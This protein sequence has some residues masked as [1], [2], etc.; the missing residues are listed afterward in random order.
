ME[1]VAELNHSLLSKLPLGVQSV[2]KSLPLSDY[3]L[4]LIVG[5]VVIISVS[6]LCKCSNKPE[7]VGGVEFEDAPVAKKE[8][9]VK[10]KIPNTKKT[11]R[12][13]KKKS[14]EDETKPVGVNE[15][16]KTEVVENE[17]D[18]EGW[19]KVKAKKP[20]RKEE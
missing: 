16:S 15:E 8:Q 2:F 10:V 7:V 12:A 4:L 1:Q 19:E 9:Q 20:K 6:I 14:K 11:R 13:N 5:V 18:E 3:S 17:D